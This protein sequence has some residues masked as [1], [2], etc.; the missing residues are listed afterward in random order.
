MN[1]GEQLKNNFP[2]SISRNGSVFSS[3]VANENHNAVIES[4]LNA[5]LDYMTEWKNTKDLYSSSDKIM[6]YITD[7]FSYL[8]QFT[9]ESEESFLNRVK[10]IFYRGGDSHWGSI[11]NILRTFHSYFGT[12]TIYIAEN[13]DEKSENLITDS[14]FDE[15][16]L[17]NWTFENAEL[18]KEARFIKSNGVVLKG[19]TSNITQTIE[20]EEG[21]TYCL[22]VFH[23]GNVTLY[24]KAGSGRKWDSETEQYIYTDP[25]KTFEGTEWKDSFIWFIAEYNT[26][27]VK[28]F[29]AGTGET[30]I[31][32]PRLFLKKKQPSFTL[33]VQFTGDSS[34]NALA[35]AE[36]KDDP[37]ETINY[38]NA[39]Y[40][41]KSYLTGANSGYAIDL[42]Q[43]LLDY[44]KSIGVA[45]YMEIVNRDKDS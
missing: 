27:T 31:D 30:W 40:Y 14:D 23:K 41:D 33:Y 37:L 10:A 3:L 2:L 12:D 36:G 20:V 38:D 24:V 1:V 25:E 4:E 19:E 16:G 29:G 35:L 5:L 15:S 44:V 42:Y 43:E 22:H 26:V 18:S 17:E 6:T 21:K 32:Y 11:Y 39:G 45:A 7:F 9:D 13:T 28:I 8:S 34:K